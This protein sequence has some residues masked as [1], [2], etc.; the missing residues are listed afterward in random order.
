MP[1]ADCLCYFEDEYPHPRADVPI[2]SSLA[3]ETMQ[4]SGT[5]HGSESAHGVAQ[6][7]QDC[8]LHVGV[9]R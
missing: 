6:P 3:V 8:R 7:R 9:I 4:D 1:I 5:K 2:V